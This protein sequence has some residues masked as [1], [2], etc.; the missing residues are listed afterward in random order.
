MAMGSEGMVMV[1]LAF[2]WA[3][4]HG[5]SGPVDSYGYGVVVGDHTRCAGV[6]WSD[7]LHL[8]VGGPEQCS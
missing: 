3:W 7:G 2:L 4:L 8:W 5:V 1:V 6:E